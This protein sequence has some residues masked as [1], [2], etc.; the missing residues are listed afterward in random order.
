M[1]KRNTSIKAEATRY[2]YTKNIISISTL[3]TISSMQ[4]FLLTA[5]ILFCESQ[6]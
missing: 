6:F 1:R 4:S 5:K 3:L 2:Q